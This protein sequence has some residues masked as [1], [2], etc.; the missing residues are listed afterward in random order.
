M[1]IEYGTIKYKLLIAMMMAGEYPYKSLDL[2]AETQLRKRESVNQLK[3]KGYIDIKVI[4]GK[5]RIRFKMYQKRKM[6]YVNDLFDGAEKYEPNIRSNGE[7]K[8]ERKDRIAEVIMM[9]M[10]AG[11]NVTPDM[12]PKADY[13]E[14]LSEEE[15]CIPYFLTSLEAREAITIKE[16]K[17]KGARFHGTLVS[18][19][20]MYNIYNMGNAMMEWVRPSEKT[21]VDFNIQYQK[22]MMPWGEESK[23]WYGTSAIILSRNMEYI[24]DFVKG[25]VTP[26]H[27]H[28]TSKN[29]VNINE[30]YD[31]TFYLPLSRQ[32]QIMLNI[33]TKKNW[34]YYLVGMFYKKEHLAKEDVK[35]SIACDAI[36]DDCYCMVFMD[37]DIGR[38]KRFVN[39]KIEKENYGKYKILC[40]NFQEEIVKKL[41]PPGMEVIPFDFETVTNSF[42]QIYERFEN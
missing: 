41:V 5:K 32:G 33:M 7:R 30:Y 40:Y 24:V 36:K 9:M 38:L 3:D 13:T 20:G 15:D 26:R 2:M 42:Y 28:G 31:H 6:E 27:G 37:G 17:G 11:V 14:P 8:L 10:E 35:M 34:H 19:G 12:K 39:I 16:D 21:A 29:L 23:E 18:L 22:R 1:N 4:N 25:N